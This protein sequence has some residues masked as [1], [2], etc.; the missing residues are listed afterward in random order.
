MHGP[1]HAVSQLRLKRRTAD[2]FQA[3]STPSS[4]QRPVDDDG[5]LPRLSR[6]RRISR[7][8]A[9]IAI[10]RGQNPGHWH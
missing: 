2:S 9:S 8:L 6:N 3:L 10:M 5:A 1:F 7:L 4:A